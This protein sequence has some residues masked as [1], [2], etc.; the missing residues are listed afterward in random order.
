[1]ASSKKS[2]AQP[3]PAAVTTRATSGT[4]EATAS[5]AS[6]LPPATWSMAFWKPI[7]LVTI[8]ETVIVSLILVIFAWPLVN[9]TPASLPVG[10]VGPAAVTS[11]VESAVD[12]KAPGGFVWTEYESAD[13]AT[14]AIEHREIYGAFVLSDAGLDV[15]TASAANAAVAQVLTQIGQQIADAT[16]RSY[17]LTVL[18]PQVTDVVPL[19]PTDARGAGLAAAA[20]PLV[21][22]G[23]VAALLATIRMRFYRQ[24]AVFLVKV[25][26]VAGA[27]IAGILQGLGILIGNWWLEW[28]AISLGIA[29]VGFVLVGLQAL[30]KFPGIIV[31]I[32]LFFI[33][34]NPISGTSLPVEFYPA[35]LGSLGQLLPLGSEVSLLRRISFFPDA[36]QTTQWIT[37]LAWTIVGAILLVT[38]VTLQ[39]KRSRAHT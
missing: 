29:A 28:L 19:P 15:L 34:G 9:A 38:G 12:G 6:P 23:I 31:G 32:L 20:L 30:F 18:S 36:S 24:R 2:T 33:I 17:G 3:N 27:A 8:M 10:I 5:G 35:P 13:A 1:M 4:S 11:A 22:A 14:A 26:F 16:A 25:S 7:I 37:L 39:K 21:I